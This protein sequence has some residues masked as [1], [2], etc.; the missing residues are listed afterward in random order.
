LPWKA[1]RRLRQRGW[2]DTFQHIRFLWAARFGDWRNGIRAASFI[3]RDDLGHDSECVDYDPISYRSFLFALRHAEIHPGKDV[4]LDYGC[5]MGRALVVAARHPFRKVIGIE[6][7][8]AL[9]ATAEANVARVKS[10]LKCDVQIVNSDA[11]VFAIPDETTVIY[12]FNPFTGSILSS[13]MERIEASLARAP[14]RLTILY[15][16]P[17]R[18][19]DPFASAK[20]LV[21]REDSRT[22]GLRFVMYEHV[23]EAGGG[24]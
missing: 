22:E 9:C 19:E 23:P 24:E 16:L 17:E 7:S 20:W 13:A 1:V 3:S 5:G 8:A 6:K 18:Q 21:Q 14:R 11:R 10:R 2:R 4:F 12:M 15:I